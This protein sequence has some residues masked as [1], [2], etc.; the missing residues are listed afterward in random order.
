MNAFKKV[1][2]LLVGFATVNFASVC[3]AQAKLDDSTPEEWVKAIDSADDHLK[4]EVSKL[5]A[6]DAYT[7]DVGLS[8]SKGKIDSF[9]S[10]VK[11][12]SAA[13]VKVDAA[14]KA[15]D[16]KGKTDNTAEVAAVIRESNES[17]ALYFA[18]LKAHIDAIYDISK[19]KATVV[20]KVALLKYVSE[21]DKK[22]VSG[23]AAV[24]STVA[25]FATALATF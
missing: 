4:A 16:L 3:V 7:K 1:V 19:Y 10:A 12:F 6:E 13:R 8:A 18:A 2:L 17:I 15:L 5:K 21:Y 22:I 23:F 24:V 20:G 9:E 11:L 25:L 14:K